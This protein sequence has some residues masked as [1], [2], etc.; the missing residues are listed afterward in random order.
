[1]LEDAQVG[2]I[3]VFMSNLEDAFVKIGEE[4]ENFTEGFQ[5]LNESSVPDSGE[6]V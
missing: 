2:S 1:M 3:S 5:I 6:K 4:E